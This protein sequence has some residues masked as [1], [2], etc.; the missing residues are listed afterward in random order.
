[1]RINMIYLINE[2]QKKCLIN[3]VVFKKLFSYL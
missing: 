1:M 2:L 3:R